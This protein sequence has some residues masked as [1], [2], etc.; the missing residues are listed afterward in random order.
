MDILLIWLLI[1]IAVEAITEILI[2]GVIFFKFREWIFNSKITFLTIIFSCGYCLSV[3]VS[4]GF[5]Y[6]LPSI[7]GILIPDLIIKTFALHR[8]SNVYHE[9]M[10]RWFKPK[11]DLNAARETEGV[12]ENTD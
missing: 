9:L 4:M 5:V 7:T 2:D 12:R 3:W 1:I 10:K 6:F 8:L 11:E